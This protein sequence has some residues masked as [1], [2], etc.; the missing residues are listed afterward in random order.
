MEQIK[1]KSTDLATCRAYEHP[2]YVD[3]GS[4]VKMAL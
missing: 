2:E 1:H 4:K 3:F